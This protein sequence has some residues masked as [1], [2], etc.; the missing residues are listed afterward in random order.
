MI[1]L[2]YSY[3]SILPLIGAISASVF[4]MSLVSLPWI[5]ARIPE[6]YFLSNNR[7]TWIWLS[8]T[9][10]I[11]Q[12]FFILIKNF[13]G[14]VLL[15]GGFLMLF[16]PG[17]GLLTIFMG[18]VL[19]DYPKKYILE[20]KLVKTPVVLKGINWLRKKANKPPLNVGS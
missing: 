9:H 12:L 10:P 7:N 15:A 2:I 17:Q 14:L 5:A 11:F 19:I 4:I 1:E 16:I 3:A 6:D 8:N 13:L 18:L 20:R